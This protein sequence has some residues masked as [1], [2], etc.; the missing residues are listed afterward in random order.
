VCDRFVESGLG[1]RKRTTASTNDW[2]LAA[3]R[4]Q[5]RV[6]G[7]MNEASGDTPLPERDT[8]A[9]Y[10]RRVYFAGQDE[11]GACPGAKGWEQRSGGQDQAYG[12]VEKTEEVN[13][14]RSREVLVAGNRG[15]SHAREERR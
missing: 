4:G 13:L 10:P 2:H 5:A 12:E 1:C 14:R 8:Y 6:Q 11:N 3:G 7:R 15:T 9:I